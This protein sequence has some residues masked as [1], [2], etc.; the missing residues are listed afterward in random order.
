MQNTITS[1]LGPA[2]ILS[3]TT[4]F[5]KFSYLIF[6]GREL[7]HLSWVDQLLHGLN[8][9]LQALHRSTVPISSR[10]NPG[11]TCTNPELSPAESS[12]SAG[13]MR[14]NHSGEV[15]AQALYCAQGLFAHSSQLRQA[16]EKAADEERD[17]LSWCHQRLDELNSK[18]SLL[19]P[20]WFSG[21]FALGTL[22]AF[23]GK[24]WNLGFLAQTELQVEQHLKSHLEKLP[25]RDHKSRAIVAQMQVDEAEHAEHAQSLGALDLP[26][27][28]PQL[29]RQSAK[30]MTCTA[31]YV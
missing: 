3:Y 11:A 9:G 31:Y 16:F 21:A 27:P 12:A 14:V 22:A 23:A 28:I 24:K 20:L 19:N 30:V 5:I 8:M 10:P 25:K 13:Y 4:R 17:H 1:M 7:R 15:C 29:M 26:W 2:S 18:P 6:M